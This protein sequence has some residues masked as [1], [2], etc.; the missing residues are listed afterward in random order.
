MKFIV[1]EIGRLHEKGLTMQVPNGQYFIS[2]PKDV[3]ANATC[4]LFSYLPED[5]FAKFIPITNDVEKKLHDRTADEI[6]LSKDRWIHL[7]EHESKKA[8]ADRDDLRTFVYAELATRDELDMVMAMRK[9]EGEGIGA[10]VS[11]V[12]AASLALC[13]TKAYAQKFGYHQIA[14]QCKN[15]L[16]DLG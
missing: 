15:A 7:H 14:A 16:R 12:S 8:D 3:P 10:M 9:K 13:A 5:Q 2:N 11:L 4:G 1:A 6:G